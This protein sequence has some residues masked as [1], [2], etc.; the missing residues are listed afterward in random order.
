MF[1]VNDVTILRRLL[2]KDE[3]HKLIDSMPEESPV[4]VV[5][6]NE[7]KELYTNIKVQTPQKR[8]LDFWSKWRDS[9]SRHPAPKDESKIMHILFVISSQ[10]FYKTTYF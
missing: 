3:I 5:N 6:E 8:I 7:R 1:Q 2:T 9:N 10:L 4:W